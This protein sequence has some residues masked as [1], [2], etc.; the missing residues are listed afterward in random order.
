WEGIRAAD[1]FGPACLQKPDAQGL[2]K[3]E[4]QSEDC[5]TLNI[6]APRQATGAPVA[7]WIHGGGFVAGSGA[8]PPVDGAGLAGRGIVLVSLNYRLGPLGF[9]AHPL[10]ERDSPDQPLG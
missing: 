10:I 4:A 7:V 8:A 6:W 9:F 5:L 1:E 2:I 3:V